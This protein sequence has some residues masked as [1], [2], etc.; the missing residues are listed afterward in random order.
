MLPNSNFVPGVIER[1]I[2]EAEKL[3]S[4]PGVAHSLLGLMK[5]QDFDIREVVACLERDPALSLRLLRVLNSARSGLRHPVKNLRQAVMLLGQRTLRLMLLTFSLQE[6][7]SK[8]PA[9][10]LYTDYWQHALTMALVAQRF[11][12]ESGEIN[13]H[14]AYTAGLLSHVGILLFAQSHS[15]IYLPLFQSAPSGEALAE[16]ERKTFGFDHAEL[17]A[18][19]LDNWNLPDELVLAARDHHRQRL[20]R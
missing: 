8:G 15:T 19:L 10:T 13:P 18:A 14:D 7:F 11:A 20:A 12:Q 5:S 4:A 1:L 17:G 2:R 16:A 3:H 6:A 9:Q